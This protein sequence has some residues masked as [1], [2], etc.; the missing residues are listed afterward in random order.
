[1]IITVELTAAIDAAGTT[2]TFYLATD[3]LN[4]LATDTP[5]NEPFETRLKDAGSI[6]VHVFSDGRTGGKTTL[7]TG[8]IVINN[9]DGKMDAWHNYSFDGRPVIIRQGEP[10]AAYPAGFTTLLNGTAEALEGDN[11]KIIIRLRDQSYIF[12][13]PL[14][15]NTYGGTNALPAGLDGTADD[16]KGQ[17]KPRIYGA[18]FNF[19]PPQVNT[20]QLIFQFN[21]GAGA[22]LNA[23]Y[24]RAVALT[25]GTDYTSQSDMETNSPNAGEYRVWPAGGYFRL[26]TKPTGQITVDATQGTAAGNRTTAQILKQIALDAGLAAG[27]IHAADVSALDAANSAVVGIAIKDETVLEALDS[28]AASIGAYYYIDRLAKLR[29]GQ[30]TAPGTPSASFYDYNI[31]KIERRPSK[32]INIPAWRITIKHTHNETVQT[33]D[34]SGG[35]TDA[36]RAWLAQSERTESDSDSDI[37]TQWLLAREIEF[38]GRLTSAADAATEATRRLNLYKVKRDIFDITVPL[39]DF[40]QSLI[41]TVEIHYERHGLESGVAFRVI[42]YTLNTIE[43]NAILTLWG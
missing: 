21:D 34:L 15:Q 5:A 7:E 14:S 32:D 11:E 38:D 13:K 19:S 30:L 9:I 41:D 33:T 29:M 40:N 23:A 42:G 1:M 18:V 25:R 36:R 10:W 28:V 6:G 12:D 8:E 43:R 3:E 22:D 4:T 16:L 39:S 26:G 2:K 24:D 31:K 17:R 20:S 37:K 35:V 27:S